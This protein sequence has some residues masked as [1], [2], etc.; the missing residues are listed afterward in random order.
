MSATPR[1]H[2]L[3]TRP[4][5][6]PARVTLHAPSPVSTGPLPPS[7][8]EP[9]RR[10]VAQGR[11]GRVGTLSPT[12]SLA[13]GEVVV[14][15]PA[16]PSAT[17]GDGE[18]SWADVLR[19]LTANFDRILRDSPAWTISLSVNTLL[20]LL[21]SLFMV[22]EEAPRRRPMLSLAFGPSTP[23]PAARPGEAVAPVE[24]ARTEPAVDPTPDAAVVP[25]PRSALPER[26][27]Q[28][29]GT[30]ASVP[31]SDAPFMGQLLSG[32]DPGR[33][34]RLVAR[35]G[36]TGGTEAAVARA[37]A[38]IVRQQRKDGF[39]SLTGPYAD[40]GS[41]ENQLA[42]TAMALLALQGA[43]N[44]HQA[45]D[46]QRAVARGWQALLATQRPEGSFE[47]GTLP[48]QH[49]LYSHAQATIALCEL[50]AMTGDRALVA[51][52]RRA[53]EHAVAAQGPA[54][55]WRY[56][57]GRDGDM[58]VSGWYMMALVSARSAGLDVPPAT[59]DRLAAF[60]ERVAVDDGIRYGYRREVEHKP[61]APITPA[62]TAEG[63]LCRLYLSWTPDDPRVVA[64]LERLLIDKKIDFA[65]DKDV[66]AWYYIT[67]VAHHAGGTAWDRWNADLREAL[68]REQVAKGR[69]AG[70]WDPA[71]DRWGHVGGRLFV[72]SLCT[73]ML[74]VYYRHLPLHDR[75]PG[76]LTP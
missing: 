29:G 19:D 25:D 33:R 51:P 36:G 7:L 9:A 70:S 16:D 10:P 30:V 52:A 3:P 57:P 24:I 13:A 14:R 6:A 66:Y 56:E 38:W 58:S 49:A 18:V 20:L 67:Q 72:T 15:I 34:E 60:V 26:P 43:G 35:G 53:L 75:G 22:R 65:A 42:A 11:D 46:H 69:E 40:G 39:W 44:T 4:A 76:S 54:G 17:A 68:P 31:V 50:A 8:P 73:W 32:R 41:Q 1:L 48:T 28:P 59:L 63:L 64:G 62:V 74:E 27:P 61:A 23:E 21:L 47:P 37:L 2:P 55:G 5:V 71:L 45:G 12:Q